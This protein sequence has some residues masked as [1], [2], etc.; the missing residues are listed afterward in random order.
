MARGG[1]GHVA[2]PLPHRVAHGGGDDRH[3]PGVAAMRRAVAF[4][5]A[6]ALVMAPAVAL[7]Q[8]SHSDSDSAPAEVSIG[9][10]DY[11]PASLSVLTGSAVMWTNES[12]RVHTV[13]AEDGS[14]DSGRV[15]VGQQFM[16]GFERA[17]SYA[18]Y[19]R[20]HPTIRGKV[21]V[22]DLL[23][24]PQPES[25]APGRS[26]PV[27]GRSSLPAGTSVTVQG[28]LGAG[29]TDVGTASVDDAGRFSVTVTPSVTTRYRAVSGSSMSPPVEL[30]VVDHSVSAR[31]VRHGRA[32]VVSALVTPPADGQRVVLQ[33][34]SRERFGWWPTRRAR[35]DAASRARFVL[36]TRRRV[37]ARVALTRSDGATVLAYSPAFVVRSR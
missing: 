12:S 23:L 35:L 3:L 28:D 11:N 22:S 1:P 17:G 2:L 26:Y 9:Y 29:F 6:A 21:E 27:G 37:R 10:S 33:V 20:L 5:A 13:T 7:A 30:V 36:H 18:Y 32:V 4:A 8:H 16:H 15:A 25:A 14:F 31:G 24:D 34:R 19:C